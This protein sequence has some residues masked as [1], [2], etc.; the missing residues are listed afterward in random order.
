[1]IKFL[2]SYY[3]SIL[4]AII[5]MVALFTPGNKLPHPNLLNFEN[6]DKL[7]HLILFM[8]LCFLL[9]LDTHAE[10]Y[11]IK[12]RQTIFIIIVSL[13]F[14]IGTEII[15]GYLIN[16]RTGSILDFVADSI[17]IFLACGF[18]YILQ[19]FISRFYRPIF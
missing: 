11:S 15:Q 3:K 5:I 7:I 14:A 12:F 13:L 1:M 19:N 8:G 16:Y 2:K 9:L 17:G 18:F 10:K 6:S 4:W